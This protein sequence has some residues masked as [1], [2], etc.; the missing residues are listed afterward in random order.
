M[1]LDLI[2]YSGPFRHIQCCR[3]FRSKYLLLHLS[4]SS[5]SISA[6]CSCEKPIAARH[7]SAIVLS[8]SL[9][10]ILVFS[11]SHRTFILAHKCMI[12]PL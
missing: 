11:E 6:S 8:A 10:H 12:T 5:S 2:F 3:R 4:S 7:V 9:S 1:A